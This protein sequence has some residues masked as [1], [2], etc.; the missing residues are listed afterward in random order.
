VK[1]ILVNPLFQAVYGSLS[2]EVSPEL[3]DSTDGR[4]LLEVHHELTSSN[5]VL[6]D[7]ACKPPSMWLVWFW[8]PFLIQRNGEP[9]K[10]LVHIHLILLG[11]GAAVILVVELTKFVLFIIEH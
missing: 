11:T 7:S 8:F 10:R 9:L 6:C 2:G 3:V 5:T 4:L 1:L